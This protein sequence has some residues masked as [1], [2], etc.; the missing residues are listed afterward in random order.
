MYK[1][2]VDHRADI[3]G[4]GC[5]LYFLLTGEPPFSDGTLAQRIAKHQTEMPAPIRQ[6]RSDCPGEL[7]GLGVKLIQ[8]DPRYRYQ[9]DGD[10]AEVL[11]KFVAAVPKGAKVTA[12]LG[13][14]PGFDDDTSS[15]SLD[16]PTSP[17]HGD[18]ITNKHDDTLA[19]ARTD[20]IRGKGISS[21]D[22]GRLV[23]VKPRHDLIEGS[24]IDLQ[25]ESGY[26]PNS[27]IAE[28][29]S[30]TSSPKL[31]RGTAPSSGSSS[32]HIGADSDIRSA[33]KRQVGSSGPGHQRGID[34][35]LLGAVM[36]A[37]L[38]AAL[39]IG[40]FLARATS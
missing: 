39:A 25:V 30:G 7:E 28:G 38:V 24:F 12:G 23:N 26:R 14:E 5:T 6:V 20:L 40:F 34:P 36:V 3:Y 9:S 4:L 19:N 35:L 32:V 13:A 2:Q 27:G 8:T 22:S 37:L 21:S 17:G 16:E 1:R 10:G 31:T 29:D 15:I 11:E 33:G 18:T